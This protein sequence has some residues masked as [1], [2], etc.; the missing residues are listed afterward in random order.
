MEYGRVAEL[1][2]EDASPSIYFVPWRDL[3]QLFALG[4]VNRHGG[5]RLAQAAQQCR[6][7]WQDKCA[8]RFSA[9]LAGHVFAPG[10]GR[11]GRAFV[12][13]GLR[14][15]WLGTRSI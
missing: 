3:E 13:P 11:E 9:A 14:P 4:I 2:S 12:R 8:P 5:G 6:Q 10:F 15:R 7:R 1:I